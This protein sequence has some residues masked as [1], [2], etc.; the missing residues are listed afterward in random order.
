MNPHAGRARDAEPVRAWAAARPQVAWRESPDPDACR[1]LVRDARRAGATTFVAVGGDGTMHTVANA[2]LTQVQDADAV[3]LGLIPLGTGNDL[4]RTLAIPSDPA[5]ALDVLAAGRTERIDLFRMAAGET[6]RYGLNASAGGFSGQVD[7]AL[8]AEMKATWG[9]LAYL[10][11]AAQV[12]PDL[13]EHETYIAFDDEPAQRVDAFNIVV[14]NG[15]TAAG[16]RRVAPAA[17]PCDG[18]LDVVIVRW[19]SAAHLAEVGT[20]LVAGNYLASDAVMHR[21]VKRVAVASDPGM[22]FNVDGELVTNQ[23][24]RFRVLAHRLRMIVGP[25]FSPE[26]PVT[27]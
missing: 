3:R 25:D 11:G 13:Q 8:S 22:W 4:A 27:G 18:R 10:L 6:L 14:A 26:P 2:L 7:E 19:G 12:L 20:R 5:S 23:P 1:R 16:G 24:V 21:R 15:R 9:P 17:N